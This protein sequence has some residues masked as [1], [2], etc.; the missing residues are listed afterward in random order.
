MKDRIEPQIGE[1]SI[2]QD[3]E[4]YYKSPKS[5]VNKSNLIELYNRIKKNYLFL[6]LSFVTFPAGLAI[7]YALTAY[8]IEI[9]EELEVILI[10]MIVVPFFA[11]NTG[12]ALC[13]RAL[14]K[15]A[16]KWV[17]INLFLSPVSY[18]VTMY[19]MRS[20]V[21]SALLDLEDSIS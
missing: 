17:L 2:A 3:V 9:P 1:A 19:M 13:A 15:S 12:L 16:L 7:F 18:P 11:Y 14:N 8:S 5:N 21:K 20:R 10:L 6:F 4:N